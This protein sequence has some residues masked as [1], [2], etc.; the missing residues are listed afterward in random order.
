MGYPQNLLMSECAGGGNA[1][2]YDDTCSPQRHHTGVQYDTD[3]TF[4]V[5]IQMHTSCPSWPV[6]GGVNVLT[7]AR[8]TLLDT[9][10]TDSAQY[11]P[12]APG[13]SMQRQTAVFQRT[14]KSQVYAFLEK[15]H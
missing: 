7:R 6:T 8:L 9:I 13:L 11:L 10:E 3:V 12:E 1:F 2:Y 4:C 5:E 15:P 14:F